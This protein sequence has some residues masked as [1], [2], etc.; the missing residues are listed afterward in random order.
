MTTNEANPNTYYSKLE[1]FIKICRTKI[2]DNA[3]CKCCT[4]Y[5]CS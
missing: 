2:A 1:S 5:V 4:I 3:M